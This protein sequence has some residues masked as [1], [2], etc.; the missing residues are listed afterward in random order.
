M[1]RGAFDLTGRIALVTGGGSGLGLAMARGLA[2]HGASVVLV[3]RDAGKLEHAVELIQRGGGQA[4]AAVCDLLDPVA[5][6]ELVRGTEE[7]HGAIDI[8]INNAGIQHRQAALEVED[9]DW[10]RVLDTN[11]TVPFRLA[12]QVGRGMVSRGHGKIIN[13]LSVLS[14]LGRPSIVPYTAAKGGLKMLTKGL[15]VEL[16]PSGVQVNGIAPGYIL[17]EMNTAL[18][19]DPVFSSWLMGRTPAKR[20]GQPQDLSG[21]AVFLAST[22]SDFVTGH[23]L[24]VDGGLTASV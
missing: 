8:L 2:E 24:A 11:L 19:E 13:T 1:S 21:A 22:A 7:Q 12:R 5:L 3:G 18:S 14:S 15:A 9:A 10:A 17:T 16:A 6:D 20:W 4:G 23:V